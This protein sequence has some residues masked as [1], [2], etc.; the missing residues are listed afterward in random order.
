M[1]RMWTTGRAGGTRAAEGTR[2]RRA[3][4]RLAPWAG[5]I[6]AALGGIEL[7]GW[8]F[9]SPALAIAVAPVRAAVMM[10]NTAAGLVLAG[11]ALVLLSRGWGSAWRVRGG[12]VL[13]RVV[14]LVGL[15]TLIEYV[16]G[17]DILGLDRLLFR[18]TVAAQITRYPGR[19]APAAAACFVTLGLALLLLDHETRQ[20][21]RISEFLALLV[22]LVGLQAVAGYGYAPEI[23]R[24]AAATPAE[25]NVVVP[26]SILASVAFLLGAVGVLASRPD[27][28]VMATFTGDDA[29]GFMARRLLPAAILLP[30]VLGSLRLLGQRA[31]LYGT[32]VGTSL[33]A[34][35][36][37]VV[38][39]ALVA[40]TANAL[41][42][43]DRER[44]RSERALSESEARFR[45]LFEEAGIGIALLDPEGRLLATN[46]ALERMLGYSGAE[47]SGKAFTEITH[48]EDIEKDVRLFRQLIE[49]RR[50]SYQIEKRYIRSDG[51]V[52]WGRLTGSIIR[53]DAGRVLFGIG[54]LED[55]TARRRADEERRR[56]TAVIDAT[57][58]FVGTAD[59]QLN[60]ISLNRAAREIVGLDAEPV[61]GLMIV[62][63][64]PPWAAKRVLEEG[65][66]TAIRQGSWRGE[67]AIAGG[68]GREIPVSQVILSHRGTTGEVEFLSTVIR[69]I[70][71]RK[72]AEDTARFLA[73]ASRAL[74]GSLDFEAVLRSVVDL[75]VP[76]RADF[77]ILDLAGPEG[78]IRRIAAKHADPDRQPLLDRLQ[79]IRPDPNAP[80]GAPTVL[81]TG[82]SVRYRDIDLRRFPSLGRGAES[83]RILRRLDPR[84]VLVVPLIA[85]GRVI[86]ALSLARS[87]PAPPYDDDEQSLIEGLAGRAALALEN[88]RLYRE[89][90][91]A[92]RTRDQ[93]LRIVAHDLRNPLNTILLTVELL[94]DS[95][96]PDHR[97][98]QRERLDIIGRSVERAR[99]LIEDLLDVARLQAGRL[100]VQ[101]GPVDFAELLRES[102][103]HHRIHADAKSIRLDAVIPEQLPRIL[104]DRD[105]ILQVLSNLIGNAIKFTPDG[106]RVTVRAESADGEVLASVT[107]TGPGIRRED[108]PHLFDPFWQATKGAAEG[109]GLGLAIAKGIVEAHGG[110]V[111]VRS[112]YGAG[113][114]FTIVLP[115]AAG[116]GRAREG[117]RAA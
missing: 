87:S 24:G 26:M 70:S 21:R 112:E 31:G 99:R 18:E 81:K 115:A 32:A 6:V 48:P 65:V 29:G 113:S 91:N 22:G 64:H 97:A 28:G 56:L 38:F 53:D 44:R 95:L 69:D 10:P 36:T 72:R 80:G 39:I 46:A 33:L 55:I 42:E 15:L 1:E 94:R 9:G 20:G 19:P 108:L 13:A 60:V 68:D 12:R 27:R 37:V 102:V 75:V 101:R 109:A 7:I 51:A 103:E 57:T 86:G 110:R 49:G 47:L 117:R 45:A 30:I 96:P 82:R 40:W 8:A 50:R 25:Q 66:P 54:M 4:R 61:D 74:A 17:A 63:M 58:D 77:C 41:R 71:E 35:M 34:V 14:A 83:D 23:L 67:T 107:D 16:T 78:E 79:R 93:V 43:L 90:R 52:V 59:A 116:E 89:S 84:S 98:E 88:A 104:A 114:T 5:W 100:P 85:R 92:T 106:G 111:E 2:A 105:R 62:D 11:L 3:L 76:A 73:E